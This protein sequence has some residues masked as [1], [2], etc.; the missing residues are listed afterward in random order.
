M[1]TIK[2]GFIMRSERDNEII[3]RILNGETQISLANEYG[4]TRQRIS[5]VYRDYLI[6]KR[7]SETRSELELY[8]LKYAKSGLNQERII[9]ILA[10]HGIKHWMDFDAMSLDEMTS[11]FSH[12]DR[13][14]DFY[15]HILTKVK[16]KIGIDKRKGLI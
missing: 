16:W 5:Q 12:T 8:I 4:V 13:D 3:T 9:R 10:E 11:W 7:R 1:K 15:R 6:E 2:G 14:G